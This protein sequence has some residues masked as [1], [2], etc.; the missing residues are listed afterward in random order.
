MADRICTVSGCD[1]KAIARGWCNKHYSR[2]R[3]HGSTDSLRL[4]RGSEP[5]ACSIDGCS[6]PGTGGGGFGWCSTH[7][8]RF[9]RHGSPHFTSRVVGD[10]SARFA[11]YLSEG[12][13]PSHAPDLG[14]CWVWL[15]ALTRDGYAV[16]ASDLPTSSAHRWS[17]RHHVADLPVGLELDHLC[18]VRPCV[19]PWHLDPVPPA[20][21][22]KRANDHQRATR[23]AS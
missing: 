1:N 21:N 16:M 2:W 11:G 15:G 23:A 8:R 5:P 20:I 12:P 10:D 3:H 19:N 17:Y 4:E 22:K 9:Q 18:H 7:Y 14:P 6:R 13:T